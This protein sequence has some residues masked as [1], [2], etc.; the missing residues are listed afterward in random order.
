MWDGRSRM[1]AAR[2]CGRRE[3]QTKPF[4]QARTLGAIKPREAARLARIESLR[5][6]KSS[7]SASLIIFGAAFLA[8]CGAALFLVPARGGATMPEAPKIAS[9]DLGAVTLELPAWTPILHPTPLFML[10]AGE[11]Q[12]LEIGYEAVRSTSGEGREDR[13]VFGAA[14]RSDAPFME[15]AIYRTG[16]EAGEPAPFFVDLSRRAAAAGVAVAKTTPGAPMRS[17]FG[18]MES[19]EAKLSLNGVERSCLAFRRAVPGEPLRVLGWYCA[20]AGAQAKGAELSCLIERL[21]LSGATDDQ[22]LRD[23]FAS[24]HSRHLECSKPA[25]LL[26][27]S[28]VSLTS[29]LDA[30]P[31]HRRGT[32][33][34][35][36]RIR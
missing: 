13:L 1:S 36:R 33:A 4:P 18:E 23:A 31:P 9:H 15:I 22:T 5:A 11:L 32:K 25:P 17:K 21:E 16:G 3:G 20:P 35:H 28:A 26:A 34:R 30:T 27:N 19:A 6:R 24:A 8:T 2:A 29:L 10:D 12:K 7:A 14:A